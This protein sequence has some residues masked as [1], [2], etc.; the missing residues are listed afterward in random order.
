M[1]LS[2]VNNNESLQIK[3]D[4][5]AAKSKKQFGGLP[6]YFADIGGVSCRG[7]ACDHAHFLHM[8]GN[9]FCQQSLKKINKQL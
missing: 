6:K 7:C 2:V 1:H 5:T 3:W 4:R 8:R 9:T